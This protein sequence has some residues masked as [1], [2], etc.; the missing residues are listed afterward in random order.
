[1]TQ[2]PQAIPLRAGP[3]RAMMAELAVHGDRTLVLTLCLSLFG[4]AVVLGAQLMMPGRGGWSQSM[5]PLKL[6][7]APET[8]E[9]RSAWAKE[10]GRIR[11]RTQELPG[12]PHLAAHAPMA[13]GYH[14]GPLG[15]EVPDVPSQ[16]SVSEGAGSGWSSLPAGSVGVWRAAVDL[17]NLTETFQGNPVL[18]SYFSA[19]RERIQRT[20]NGHNWF[21]GAAEKSGVVY[22]GFVVTRAGAIQSASVIGARSVGS[23]QLQAVA[24]QIVQASGPFLPFPPSFQESAKAIMVPLEFGSDS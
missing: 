15:P 3:L 18:Y 8:T 23:N 20:A 12:L 6:V 10:L 21:S 11:V 5:K 14:V 9:E 4:H 1:M 22:V 17:T 7:Y 24:L 16:V 13:E 2:P 19:I